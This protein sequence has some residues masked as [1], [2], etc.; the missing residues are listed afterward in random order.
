M[1]VLV[2]HKRLDDIEGTSIDTNYYKNQCQI[3]TTNTIK[4]YEPSDQRLD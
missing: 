1:E 3:D 4:Q 2:Y